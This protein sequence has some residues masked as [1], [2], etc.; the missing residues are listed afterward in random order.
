MWFLLAAVV[1]AV[2]ELTTLDL[3]FLMLAAGAAAG[4]LAAGVTGSVVVGGVAALA[5]AAAML[6]VVRPIALRHLR[7][8]VEARTGVAALVGEQAVVLE[9]VDGHTGRI[10]LSGEVWSARSYDGES[11][12]APGSRVS[13]AE[14]RGA[15]ALV[16]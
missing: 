9:Q 7:Q 10:K 6:G 16:L 3:L 11:V 5:T 2:V 8:P 14:I 1:L 4:A 15:T 12:F 13:V